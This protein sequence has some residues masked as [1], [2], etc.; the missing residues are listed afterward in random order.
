MIFFGGPNSNGKKMDATSCV[1]LGFENEKNIKNLK[2]SWEETGLSE[3]L[4]VRMGIHTDVC[5]VGNFGFQNQFG[6]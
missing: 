4:D 6:L 1:S 2:K 3:S 5:T